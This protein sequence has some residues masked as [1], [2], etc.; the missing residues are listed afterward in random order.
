MISRRKFLTNTLKTGFGTAALASFPASIQKALA[1]PANNKTGTIQ[2]VEHVIILMQENRSFDHYFG[3]LKGVRGFGDRFTIPQMN[4]RTVWQQLRSNGA[5]LTPFHLDGSKN[6]AQRVNGTHH[7]WSDSQKAWGNGSISEWPKHKTDYSMG[8]FKEQEIPYQFALANAFTICDAYHCSMHTGTD[9][10]RS[11]H[12][13][14]TNGAVPTNTAFVNNEWDWIDGNPANINVGYTWKTYAERLEEAGIDWICYQNMPDEWGD[15]MLGAFRTFKKANIDSGYPVSSGGEKPNSPYNP[16]AQPLPYKAYN[17]ETDNAHNPLYKGI[18]NTLPGNNPEEYLDSFRRDVKEGK[19][20]QVAWI[21]APSVYCEHPGPSSPVQGA[22]FIQ[23]VLD[24]LTAVP[25][26][27]SKTVLL[28][29]F[30]E[31]D[32]YFDHVPSPSAPSLLADKKTYAGKSTLTKEDMQYEYFVHDAPLGSKSQ[33]AKDFGVYGPGPRVPLFVISP[34]SR[35]GW[36]NSQVFDH[37]SVLMFLE[38]R[39]GVKETNISPYRRAVCGDLTSAFNFKTPNEDIL[40]ELNGKQSRDQADQLRSTQEKLPAVPIPTEIKSP[41]QATGIRLSRALPYELHTSARC[42]EDGKVKL[43]FSNTGAQAAVFH[44]YDK[45]NLSREPK[46]YV[47]EAGKS[48]DDLWN[49][50]EDN[51]GLYDLWV[52]GPNGFHRHF[53]GDV[54]HLKDLQ[55]NPEIRVCYDIANGDVYV[56][57]INTGIKDVEFS[58][59]P[60]AYRADAPLKISV[61]AGQTITQ[62]WK[63]QESR[64]W[65]DFAVTSGNDLKFYRRFAGRVETGQDSVSDP[66]MV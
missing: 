20:P 28:I 51:L 14:G 3:T 17:R 56:D 61:K 11:F 34:W 5:I 10:N 49:A 15:N 22:W 29:N 18:A 63:L 37:T 59:S 60:L 21:N 57:L 2:D 47:V 41:I 46:R 7:T 31:N 50:K 58:I 26:V 66:A 33:P 27:W 45:L 6:N 35:G 48:L 55:I 19:L 42:L 53:K 36:V 8:Y 25:E 44:V 40:P 52:L 43:I 64:Q 9:A 23:E 65:Y 32:G 12:L 1:I 4:G 30:D 13:T 39:F 62:H 16:A 38:K 24:A 54:L